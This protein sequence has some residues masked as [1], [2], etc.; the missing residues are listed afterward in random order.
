METIL[1]NAETP[2][3]TADFLPLLGTD[4]IEFANEYSYSIFIL[5]YA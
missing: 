4:Y 2:V 3:Q 1:A 5:T